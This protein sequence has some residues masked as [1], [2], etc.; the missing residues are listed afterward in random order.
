MSK[1]DRGFCENTDHKGEA[2]NVYVV[3]LTEDFDGDT[4][5]WCEAC[6]ERDS[7]MIA[8]E[9]E[10]HERQMEKIAELIGRGFTSG[11]EVDFAWDLKIEQL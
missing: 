11:R 8:D 7:E 10:K 1:W 6:R 4:C 5:E 9:D 2:K 3:K